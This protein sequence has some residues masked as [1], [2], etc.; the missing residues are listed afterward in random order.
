MTIWQTNLPY[1]QIYYKFGIRIWRR[2]L[3]LSPNRAHA[4]SIIGQ[5]ADS[6]WRHSPCN[7]SFLAHIH[8]HWLTVTERV[9]AYSL[10]VRYSQLRQFCYWFVV[11]LMSKKMYVHTFPILQ[12]ILLYIIHWN[13]HDNACI[14][15]TYL[16]HILVSFVCVC[17]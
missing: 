3:C 2:H 1:G 16:I 6:S 15:L 8:I 17:V 5:G 4:A 7:V 14:I 13:H 10:Y 11:S 9:T 12:D